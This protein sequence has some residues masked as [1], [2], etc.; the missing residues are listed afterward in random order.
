MGEHEQFD[1]HN[2]P[3]RPPTIPTEVRCLKCGREYESYLMYWEE[4][5]VAGEMQKLW[6]CP[7]DDCDGA[8]FGFDVF[9]TDPEYVNE[10]G[11]QMCIWDEEEQAECAGESYDDPMLAGETEDDYDSEW[12]VLD[13]PYESEYE[14]PPAEAYWVERTDDDDDWWAK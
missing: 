4:K 5:L 13:A 12:E 14:E 2:D 6:C 7:H 1:P 10:E 9:P 3:F 8:G 11:E